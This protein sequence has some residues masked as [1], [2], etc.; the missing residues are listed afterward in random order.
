MRLLLIIMAF[1]L[2]IKSSAQKIVDIRSVKNADCEL[3]KLLHNN[4][5]G[6]FIDYLFSAD[7]VLK[8]YEILGS[9]LKSVN[10]EKR[11]QLKLSM[12]PYR[13]NNDSIL[14][15]G[16]DD[17]TLFIEING[18]KTLINFREKVHVNLIGYKSKNNFIQPFFNL[19]IKNC[20]LYFS[21][22]YNTKSDKI[23]ITE[24]ENE[25]TILKI[26]K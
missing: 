12:V 17:T 15:I 1:F 24:Y 19:K 8:D 13:L 2:S 25:P 7:K 5:K 10:D 16:I 4:G 18:Q 23:R 21:I 14:N 3:K 20:T 26:I 9:I 11:G 22:V 6:F